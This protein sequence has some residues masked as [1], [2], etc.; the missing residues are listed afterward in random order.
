MTYVEKIETAMRLKTEIEIEMTKIFK[1]EETLQSL[2]KEVDNYDGK[3]DY[4]TRTA[5][6][7]EKLTIE[8]LKNGVTSKLKMLENFIIA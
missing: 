3:L 2:N 8:N 6:E 5:M 4:S 7:Y 1:A